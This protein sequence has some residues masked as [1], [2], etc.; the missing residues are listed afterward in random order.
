MKSTCRFL[1]VILLSCLCFCVI[2]SSG[3]AAETNFPQ[4]TARLQSGKSLKIVCFGDSVTGVYYH[5][6]SRRAYTDMVGIAIHKLYPKSQLTMI[7]AGI[8]GHT[9]VNALARIDRNVLKQKPTLVTVMFGLNDMTRVPLETYEANLITIIKKCRNVGSEVLLCTPNN[10]ISTAGRPSE[11]LIKYC[12]VVRKVAKEKSVPLCDCYRQMDLLRK[13]NEQAWRFLL[14]DEIHPNMDGHKM[15][16]QMIAKSITSQIVSLDDVG[17][18]LPILP[19]TK[20]LLQANKPIKIIAMAPLD[21]LIRQA[22]HEVAPTAKLEI[23]AWPVQGKTLKQI[24]TDSKRIVRPQK[25]D[26]VLIAIPPTAMKGT[27]AENF[28]DYSWTM[29]YSLNFGKPT[30]DCVIVHPTVLTSK[31]V[32]AKQNDFVRNVVR[33]QDLSLIDRKNDQKQSAQ[34]IVTEWLKKQIE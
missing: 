19:R 2:A 3:R 11:V 34:E 31:I 28:H 14:S 10:V 6:G 7:N 20:S 25:P 29:N 5:T 9:T 27:L 32:E 22:F 17:P 12:D 15:M 24:H 8:S 16:A 1:S 18:P 4:T 23:I 33:A 21:K 26:L 30:W 13:K